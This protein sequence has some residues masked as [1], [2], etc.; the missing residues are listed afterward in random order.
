MILFIY[1]AEGH[2]YVR[3][4]PKHVKAITVYGDSMNPTLQHDDQVLINTA[5]NRFVDDA[6]YVIQ[7]GNVLRLKRIKL[8]LDGSIEVKSNNNHGFGTE[9][10]NKEEAAAFTVVGKVL[11]F[12]FGKFDL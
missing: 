8:K 1:P 3:L 5:C 9:I 10:Y 2:A 12:K 11:P 7:Q 4:E 6:I